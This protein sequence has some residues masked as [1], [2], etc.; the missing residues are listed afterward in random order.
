MS[1]TDLCRIIS[2]AL[3]LPADHS[4]RG[5]TRIVDVPGW[6]SFGWVAVILALETHF[7]RPVDIDGVRDVRCIRDILPLFEDNSM[8][9]EE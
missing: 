3:E 8:Q 4:L 6:D 5:D 7:A 2:E 1:V 9:K